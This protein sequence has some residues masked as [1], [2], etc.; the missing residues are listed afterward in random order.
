MCILF[1]ISHLF[2]HVCGWKGGRRGLYTIFFCLTRKMGLVWLYN[3]G[4]GV[5]VPS[6][7]I[8]A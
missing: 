4:H 7:A 8:F 6:Q 1:L 2:L 5:V 3:D